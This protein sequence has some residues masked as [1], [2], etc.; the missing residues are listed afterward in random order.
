MKLLQK[1]LEINNTGNEAD[2][3]IPHILT[4]DYSKQV[5]QVSYHG[6]KNHMAWISGKNMIPNAGHTYTIKNWIEKVTDEDGNESEIT[7]NDFNTF[8]L[9]N[10]N[11]ITGGL[12]EAVDVALIR[13]IQT[14]DKD[15][16]FA[17]AVVLNTDGTE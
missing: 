16:T 10:D 3:W 5:V 6:Y 4:M 14:I 2:I 9:P 7:H 12:D 1:T 13:H 8:V 17:Y 11:P 15:T